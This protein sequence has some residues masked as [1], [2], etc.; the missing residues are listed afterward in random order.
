M[1]KI[2]FAFVWVF[3]LML[4]VPSY[5]QWSNSEIDTLTSNN[6]RDNIDRKNLIKDNAGNLH[7][8][9]LEIDQGTTTNQIY[10]SKKTGTGQWSAP[11]SIASSQDGLYSQYIG[12]NKQTGKPYI[13]FIRDTGSVRQVHVASE[14]GGVWSYERITSG[15]RDTYYPAI[16]IDANGKIHLAWVAK[17]SSD[18]YK[19]F[20]STDLSGSFQTQEL[21]QSSPGEFGSG[22]APN[23]ALSPGGTAHITYRAGGFG[24]YDVQYVTNGSAGSVTWDYTTLVTPNTDDYEGNIEIGSDATIHVTLSGEDASIFPGVRDTYYTKKPSGSSWTTSVKVSTSQRGAAGSLYI[25]GQGFAH[26]ALNQVSGNFITG[27]VFYATNMTGSWTNTP[28]IENNQTY[29]S[30]LV[31]DNN[32]RG[33]MLGYSGELFAQQEIIIIQSTDIITSVPGNIS[34]F[35]QSYKLEQN[36]PNPFNPSTKIRF[37][38]PALNQ[39][40]NVAKLSVFNSLGQQVAVL[41]NRELSPGTYQYTFDG[42]GL[43]SG[44]YF[45]K[46]QAGDFTETK[47][48]LLIK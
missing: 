29:A 46:L 12:V 41:V 36:F 26:V 8:C 33:Q 27:N 37:D 13:A 20:Y 48:M 17:N 19:I 30:N 43:S 14:T 9:W 31:L 2:K 11:E 22:A 39:G 47:K 25:D 35:P 16:G 28:I 34:H 6:F 40:G 32:G 5:A 23:I 15:T 1:N 10:Y 38:I 18:I 42:A 4:T 44:M 45:Y 24:D 7:A 21:A 3:T